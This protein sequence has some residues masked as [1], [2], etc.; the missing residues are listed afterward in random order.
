[1]PAIRFI[2]SHGEGFQAPLIVADGTTVRQL[3]DDKFPGRS[4][5]EYHITV[6]GAPVPSAYVL[7]LDDAVSMIAAP[8][9]EAPASPY[10]A[11][12]GYGD[13]IQ[14]G[15]INNDGSG[16]AD[17]VR[18]T[19]GTTLSAFVASKGFQAASY[20]IKVNGQSQT[21]DYVLRANDRVSV[22]PS[23]IQGASN[24]EVLVIKNDNSGFAQRVTVPA[25]WTINDLLRAQFGESVSPSNYKILVNGN[26][27]L[28]A[29]QLLPGSRVS[30]TP[31]KI[32]G[33]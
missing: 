10:Q 15:F 28:P 30:F 20:T 27:C 13:Q 22:T 17:P 14:I 29:D 7:Q 25:A 26:N 8:R 5:A 12:N 3:F 33:A 31:S 18:V 16:F 11:G 19:A 4:P 6:N 32:R 24:V 21:A 23:R 9:A 2:N 1:M